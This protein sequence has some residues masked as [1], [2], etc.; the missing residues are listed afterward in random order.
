MSNET[1]LTAEARDALA[2]ALKAP[3]ADTYVLYFKTHAYHWN[4][5]GPNFFS[6]HNMFEE[7]YTEMWTALDTIAERIRALGHKAPGSGR[8]LAAL[9]SI[10]DG[11]NAAPSAQV[12]IKNLVAGHEVLIGNARKVSELAAE[13]GDRATEDL[14]NARIDAHE[15]AAWML[16]ASV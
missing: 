16:R 1:G 3:L 7:Q 10:E 4:V 14:M 5:E 15:K 11:D 9:T 13:H 8:E 2:E 12:M 6:L